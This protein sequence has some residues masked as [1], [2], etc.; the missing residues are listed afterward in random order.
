MTI[1][2][3]IRLLESHPSDMRVVVE[4]YEEGFDDVSPERIEV[5]KIQLIRGTKDWQC[6]HLE[7]AERAAGTPA[8][9]EVVDALALLRESH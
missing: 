8:A 9:D 2:E 5:I 7:P 3:L 1:G 6:R 4:G